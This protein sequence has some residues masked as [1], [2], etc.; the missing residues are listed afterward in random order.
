MIL[1]IETSGTAGSVALVSSTGPVAE[2]ELPATGRRHARMLVPEIK[3]LLERQAVQLSSLTGVAVSI[4]PGS[5]TG[6]RVGVVCAKTLAYALQIPILAVDTFQAIAVRQ[7]DV[8]ADELAVIA[9]ALRGEVFVRNYRRTPNSWEASS[10][11]QIVPLEDWLQALPPD[12]PVTGPG[13]SLLQGH[14]ARTFQLLPSELADPRATAIGMLGR[15]QL[16]AGELA[17]P[18]LLEPHYIRRSAAEEKADSR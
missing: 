1:A 9:D 18:W 10:A 4:G 6:L 7:V 14:P 13:L 16:L 17:D 11:G 15:E 3:L 12:M 2:T 8:Q 5:F